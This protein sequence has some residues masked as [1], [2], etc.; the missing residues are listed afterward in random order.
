MWNTD[1][2]LKG[3]KVL[4][5]DD[6]NTMRLYFTRY[7]EKRNFEVKACAS[8]EEAWDELQ[9]NYYPLV[10]LDWNMPGMTGAEV[11]ERLKQTKPVDY[12]YIILITSRSDETDIVEGLNKGADDYITKPVIAAELEA[13]LNAAERVIDYE[14]QLKAKE[15]EVR[16]ACYKTLTEL[17]E[18]RDHESDDH[19]T[20]VGKLCGLL[21]RQMGL[22]E[23]FCEDLEI[24][25]PM[26]DIGKV[27]IP[28]GILHVPRSLWNQEYEVVKLHTTIGWQILRG[29]PAFEL[30][31]LIAYTH[32]EHWDGTG[33]PRHLKGEQI[34][35][36]G[37]IC[38][39]ADCYD[40]LRSVK[41]YGTTHSHK[42]AIDWISMRS[43]TLFDPEVV[44]AMN[45]IARKMEKLFNDTYVSLLCNH[46]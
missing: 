22:E 14:L 30:A 29:K 13:R 19:M 18:T 34:P 38:A 23:S 25:A 8:G 4:L 46:P 24:F 45:V 11:C 37:R 28:D 9:K 42:Q 17:A 44:S 36:C 31:A 27:G 39:V 2:I 16:L 33:Y 40:S 12:Q 1:A 35:V 6:D 5:A 32:H 7:L 21:A 41:S 15:R 20:R 3:M 43:G 10:M 26:H